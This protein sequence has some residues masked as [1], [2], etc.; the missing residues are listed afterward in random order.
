MNDDKVTRFFNEYVIGGSIKKGQ[1]ESKWDNIDRCILEAFKK[2]E[3]ED[4]FVPV[5]VKKLFNELKQLE[6]P[7]AKRTVYNHLNG[8]RPPQV[9]KKKSGLIDKGLI[10]KSDR[11]QYSQKNTI[12]AKSIAY[13]FLVSEI[14]N[15]N[16]FIDDHL[17]DEYLE[18]KY[19]DYHKITQKEK[20][21]RNKNPIL[22]LIYFW[23]WNKTLNEKS[24]LRYKRRE[25]YLRKLQFIENNSKIDVFSKSYLNLIQ[26]RTIQNKSMDL[27]LAILE[28]RFEDL[29]D[30]VSFNIIISYNP[31]YKNKIKNESTQVPVR[32]KEE[33]G[34][35]PEEQ[36]ELGIKIARRFE[37]EKET[38]EQRKRKELSKA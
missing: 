11:G 20:N 27:I 1:K 6:N 30:N 4:P 29:I 31:I 10:I 28:E 26:R 5:T 7:I 14:Y 2:I 13:K 8:L 19:P 9:N 34:L 21:L 33:V 35:T 23:K 36:I 16:P 25:P 3:T 12:I 18:L 22:Q 24:K 37:Y 32:E 15:K 17:F 38:I